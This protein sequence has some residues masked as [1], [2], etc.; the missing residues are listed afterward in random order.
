MRGYAFPAGWP[1]FLS[2]SAG[3]HAR[4]RACKPNRLHKCLGY[5]VRKKRL[6][7]NPLSKANLPEGW[8]PP[9]APDDTLD[10]RTVRSRVPPHPPRDVRHRPRRQAIPVREWQPH[11][12]IHLVAGLAEGPRGLAHP[13]AARDPA[14]ETPLRP[15]A[16]RGHLA[17]QLRRPRHRGCRLGRPLRRD[18]HAG[19][20]QLRG[21]PGRRLGRPDGSGPAPGGAMPW[22]AYGAQNLSEASIRQHPVSENDIDV[23]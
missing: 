10:P 19:R 20:R 22:G 13:R 5:A 12:A 7:K 16:L 14:D 15:A 17:A 23:I 3:G 2:R 21:R 18:A 9:Q 8:T 6:T 4:A 1:E 11:P